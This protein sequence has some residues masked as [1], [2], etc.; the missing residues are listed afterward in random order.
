MHRTYSM[1]QSRAPT[2]SQIEKP[3][4]PQSS[5]KVGRLFGT[6]NIGCGPDLSK[7]LSQLVKMEKNLMRSMELVGRERRE[8]ARQLS[9]WGEECD[10]DVSDITDKLGVL[11]FEVGELEDQF[12]DRYDQYRVTI[13]GV[14]NIESS[15]QPSR[16]RK[17]KIT[18]QI[19]QLKYKDPTSP[20]IVVLEQELVRAEAESLV[21]EAQLS[22]ITREKIKAAFT[23]QFDAL[24]EHSEKLALIAG[25]GKHLLELVDDTPVTP[26]ETRPAYDGYEASKGIIQDCEDALTNWVE[27]KAAVRSRLS[28]RGSRPRRTH[29][30]GTRA[31]AGEGVSLADQ[32][33][34]MQRGSGEWVPADE[35]H[36]RNHRENDDDYEDITDD[37]NGHHRHLDSDG[38]RGMRGA[39]NGAIL[40]YGGAELHAR[41]GMSNAGRSGV[42]T[43]GKMGNGRSRKRDS[44]VGGMDGGRGYEHG[45]TSMNTDGGGVSSRANGGYDGR[46]TSDANIMGMSRGYDNARSN[47][48]TIPVAVSDVGRDSVLHVSPGVKESNSNLAPY[49]IGRGGVG[50]YDS[51]IPG[52]GYG[53][54]SGTRTYAAPREDYGPRSYAQNLNVDPSRSGPFEHRTGEIHASPH[55]E[56]RLS[57]S[58]DAASE[59]G[60]GPSSGEQ[61][62]GSRDYAARENYPSATRHVTDTAANAASI[63]GDT[64]ANAASY[65]G[66]TAINAGSYMADTVS[67]MRPMEKAAN[68]ASYVGDT[69][70]AAASYAG[71]TAANAGSYMADTVKE[72]RPMDTAANAASYIADTARSVAPP[73]GPSSNLQAETGPGV[74]E[75]NYSPGDASGYDSRTYASSDRASITQKMVDT[76]ANA[77]SYVADTAKD[78]ASGIGLTSSTGPSTTTGEKHYTGSGNGDYSSGG[79][80]TARPVSDTMANT[81]SY[82]VDTAKTVASSMGITPSSDIGNY[83][84]KNAGSNTVP[85][86]YSIGTGTGFGS[87]NSYNPHPRSRG[88]PGSFDD[89]YNNSYNTV[90]MDGGGS[91]RANSVSY[92]GGAY[93]SGHDS[94]DN[95]TREAEEVPWNTG[96]DGEDKTRMG[97]R[98]PRENLDRDRIEHE[99]KEHERTMRERTE[100]DMQHAR[101]DRERMDR[102]RNDPN[103]T[104]AWPERR[105][106]LGERYVITRD[107]G[108]A[109]LDPSP[110]GMP[111]MARIYEVAGPVGSAPRDDANLKA[112]RLREELEKEMQDT[113]NEAL[114]LARERS[115]GEPL[116]T[117]NSQKIVGPGQK[118]S[119]LVSQ[120]P[121]PLDVKRSG[122]ETGHI[123]GAFENNKRSGA[124][125]TQEA[126]LNNPLSA[127][128]EQQQAERERE[129]ER[130]VRRSSMDRH[131]ATD[132]GHGSGPGGMMTT[133][134]NDSE[135]RDQKLDDTGRVVTNERQREHDVREN[136]ESQFE[137]DDD[138]DEIRRK[139]LLGR[140][141]SKM[142]NLLKT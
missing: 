131:R 45:V 72:M 30:R 31:G 24:R 60:L 51:S 12:I 10:E 44:G 84:E 124:T 96:R 39:R 77:A 55:P 127:N 14:R 118:Y 78:V 1:R 87:G 54:G 120:D 119:S 5:T 138:D 70:T 26:G 11:I 25:Y 38:A 125:N 139:S 102:E 111:A 112:E 63:A 46:Y 69:A 18:D 20:K 141:A 133:M 82:V 75:R 4:P 142:G 6:S 110:Q 16:D 99:Q 91:R 32:D 23:Y 123:P 8:V 66:D 122:G 86:G 117:N 115:T 105:R 74:Y 101:M 140:A 98:L 129:S 137:G 136:I 62:S 3:P 132:T 41:D 73:A 37:E 108:A 17:Q 56:G 94:H 2:Q 7:K 95:P 29:G 107:G 89:S 57:Y 85:R 65:A 43:N 27:A 49:M 113:Q 40:N 109:M 81:A 15:V 88:M 80:I 92:R 35:H 106:S 135:Y 21:A 47:N 83:A 67:A 22:N 58:R 128:L 104:G 93:I 100:R 36:H 76:A 52:T 130:F 28:Q 97:Q 71:D 13:K 34:P 61:H 48:S 64:A 134:R 53:T 42:S 68:A 59:F 90:G 50:S 121:G 114:R 79:D 33:R 9:I 103:Q 126:R 116:G 19:A